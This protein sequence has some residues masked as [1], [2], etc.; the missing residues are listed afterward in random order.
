MKEGV[1]DLKEWVE[2]QS[3]R[4]Q[5]CRALKQKSEHEARASSH[6]Q[7]QETV[8]EQHELDPEARGSW[9]PLC[10]LEVQQHISQP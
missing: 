3:S 4:R 7:L 10:A 5:V 2:C 1:L 9:K 8:G 6:G